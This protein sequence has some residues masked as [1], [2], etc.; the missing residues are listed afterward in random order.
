VR[1]DADGAAGGIGDVGVAASLWAGENNGESG[2]EDE[3]GGE[4]SWLSRVLR[5]KKD[6]RKLWSRNHRR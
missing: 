5:K 1:G 6:A 3:H 4:K 2:G